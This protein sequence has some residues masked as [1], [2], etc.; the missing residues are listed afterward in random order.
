[1]GRN[2]PKKLLQGSFVEQLN[3][4]QAPDQLAP[5]HA[6]REHLPQDIITILEHSGKADN[7]PFNLLYNL[8]SHQNMTQLLKSSF[9]DRQT[10]RQ[11]C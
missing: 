3:A 4:I 5:L 10:V 8:E 9:M 7:I 6:A 1:M 11:L 2:T